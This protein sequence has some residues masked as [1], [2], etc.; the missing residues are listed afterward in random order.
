MSNPNSFK[1]RPPIGG[2]AVADA[3]EAAV[4]KMADS[5]ADLT[6][7]QA[8][9]GR[10][11]V[12]TGLKMAVGASDQSTKRF[13]EALPSEEATKAMKQHVEAVSGAGTVM[14][15]GLQEITR[16]WMNWTKLGAEQSGGAI[17]DLMEC[18][19][20]QAFFDVQ[21]R[22]MKDNLAA[23]M[24]TIQKVSEIAT[25]TSKMATQKITTHQPANI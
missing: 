11:T 6:R 16:E 14:A 18:R 9:T 7:T 19:S 4:K 12:L 15:R 2:Q 10:E 8:E 22:L 23:L 17:R 21:S 20:P 24:T 5:S 13:E 1:G 3:A 25:D